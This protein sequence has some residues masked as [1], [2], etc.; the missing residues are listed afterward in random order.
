MKAVFLD[1]YSLDRNDLD[2][3]PVRAQVSSLDIYPKT[4]TTELS[5]RLA[6]YDVILV[7]KVLLDRTSL[8]NSNAKL[9]CIAATGTDN[10]D[11]SACRDFGITVTNCQGYGTDSVAQHALGLM[12]NLSNHMFEYHQAVKDGHWH[13][14]TQ[15]CLLDYPIRE[16]AGKTL[17]IVGYGTLGQRVA[18]LGK[19]FGMNILISARPGSPPDNGRVAFD[20]LLQRVDFLSLHCPLTGA[21]YHLIGER[22]LSLMKPTACL[23]NTARGA[24]I[25]EAALAHALEERR[26]GGAGLDVVDGEPPGANCPFFKQSLPNL[27]ITPHSGWGALEAR[28]RI[29]Q[30]ISENIEKWAEGKP[31]RVV[32]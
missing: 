32:S 8:E 14:S 21:T 11:L 4:Q 27:I 26:I 3:S 30:Q 2:F 22:E 1:G 29:V 25:D 5:Q 9:I 20:E 18:E 16:L 7:N 6:L 24:L 23:I 15:F 10:I 17:G 13:K 31:F 12:L 19:A 28:Q